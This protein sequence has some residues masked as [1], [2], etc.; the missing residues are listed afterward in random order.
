MEPIHHH[1]GLALSLSKGFTIIELLVVLAIIATITAVAL[2]SQSS[3]NKTLILANTA[4]DIA[5]TIRSAESFGLGS[6]AIGSVASPGYGI[7][8]QKDTTNSFIF[9]ADTSPVTNSSCTRPD[10]KPGDKLYASTDTLVQ[11]YR[12]GNNIIISD[13]CVYS[14]ATGVSCASSNGSGLSSLD[15]VFARPN[16]DASIVVNGTSFTSYTTAC[17]KISSQNGQLSRFV[18]VAASGEIIAD[19]TS[20]P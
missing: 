6:R 18:S 16:P 1:R 11:T 19:A 15:V 14:T 2:S 9:F 3:F 5:L 10:C 20:C 7:H 13:F 12:L 17:L 4:Y 8:F